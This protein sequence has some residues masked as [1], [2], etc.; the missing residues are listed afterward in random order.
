MACARCNTQAPPSQHP[1]WCRT[2]LP[3]QWQLQVAHFFKADTQLLAGLLCAQLF[4]ADALDSRQARADQRVVRRLWP[5][6]DHFPE[7]LMATV[8]SSAPRHPEEALP[9]TPEKWRATLLRANLLAADCRLETVILDGCP[10]DDAAAAAG[11]PAGSGALVSSSAP[12]A[13]SSLQGL[14]LSEES[15]ASADTAAAL[16]AC[17]ELEWIAV[18]PPEW[19]MRAGWL[20][21]ASMHAVRASWRELESIFPCRD[22]ALDRSPLRARQ[23]HSAVRAAVGRVRNVHKLPTTWEL[24]GGMW[25]HLAELTQLRALDMSA[26]CLS[27]EQARDLAQTLPR[28]ASLE[29]LTACCAAGMPVI[30]AAAA[31]L[32]RLHTLTLEGSGGSCD[33]QL[34]SATVGA[35][36]ALRS[37]RLSKTTVQH[38][39]F[40]RALAALSRLRVLELCFVETTCAGEPDAP[41]AACA[42]GAAL[43]RIVCV[44]ARLQPNHFG[45]LLSLLALQSSLRELRLDPVTLPVSAAEGLQTALARHTALRHLA[46]TQFWESD[47]AFR[48]E[49]VFGPL[50]VVLAGHTQLTYLSCQVVP[51]DQDRVRELPRALPA[52]QNVW[53]SGFTGATM[54]VSAAMVQLP[55]LTHA[56]LE[57]PCLAPPLLG[58]VPPPLPP[59][60]HLRT[61]CLLRSCGAADDGDEDNELERD[62]NGGLAAVL[63]RLP[64]LRELELE[65]TR[66]VAFAAEQLAALSHLRSLTLRWAM[67]TPVGCRMPGH[68]LPRLSRLSRLHALVLV[69]E[70]RK[71]HG[72][73]VVEELL[74]TVSSMTRLQVLSSRGVVRITVD[75]LRH[76]PEYPLPPSLRVLDWGPVVPVD[77]LGGRDPVDEAHDFVL[78]CALPELLTVNV[79]PLP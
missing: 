12:A 23:Q 60:A 1:R 31:Q 37:L 74:L 78:G 7:E 72:Y 50:A 15:I 24:P 79:W 21:A 47:D 36:T 27:L 49:P 64:A 13:A 75:G 63:P 51:C 34:P 10:P 16:A 25:R 68:L 45:G 55:R 14:R 57:L 53:L 5:Q 59:L 52:L 70:N 44:E 42:P 41:V 6:L 22:E 40:C 62:V 18:A 66:V 69:N 38:T 39:G 33:T 35:L 65:S 8:L 4:P 17:P 61:L 76:L 9:R 56:N 26:C 71:S 58:L 11:A 73:A 3:H 48:T 54:A 46:V 32:P 43:R 2:A 30:A 20:G 67:D 29:L 77:C 19:L 28:L